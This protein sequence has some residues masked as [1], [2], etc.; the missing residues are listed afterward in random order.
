M[1]TEKAKTIFALV[2]GV[3]LSL[4]LVAISAKA[5]AQEPPRWVQPGDNLLTAKVVD[6][7][8]HPEGTPYAYAGDGSIFT[9][10]YDNY[11]YYYITLQVGDKTYVVQYDNMGGYYP[12]AWRAG[13]EVKIRKDHGISILRY[14]GV[15]VP[16]AV[17]PIREE[18]E[19]V[20]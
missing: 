1:E 8:A 7:E 2:S 9:K 20:R 5:L 14:D 11:P 15:L 10:L 13:H 16:V 19:M 17:G 12:S 18:N 6:V 4:M 3:L